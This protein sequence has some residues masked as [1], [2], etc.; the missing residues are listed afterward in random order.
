MRE[1]IVIKM[2]EPSDEDRLARF[3]CS[4]D[5]EI[6]INWNR[7]GKINEEKLAIQVAKKQV[8]LPLTREVGFVALKESV[9][10]GYGYLRFFPE[11]PQKRYT[12]S[13][14]IVIQTAF[15]KRGIGSKL[16]YTLIDY[17]TKRNLKKIWLATYSDNIE[18][19]R[20]YRRFGFEVEGIFM[21]DE[22]FDSFPRHV[23]SMAL[24]LDPAIENPRS[25]KVFLEKKFMTYG[26]L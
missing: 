18:A 14:G 20:F 24:Y 23:V 1:E 22:Y 5:D 2:L 15:Q 8:S 3:F 13:L 19:L 16:L 11:K 10:V 25:L 6:F 21:Y 26:K 7:F 4:L 9:I 12:A 17:A